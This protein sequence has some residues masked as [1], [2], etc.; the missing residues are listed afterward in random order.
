MADRQTVEA[1][2]K[3]RQ[4]T[5]REDFPDLRDRYYEP[6]LIQLESAQ[7][8]PAG[9]IVLDQQTEGACT[10]F[11]VAA[12]LNLLRQRQGS[13]SPGDGA[14]PRMLYEM[15]KLHDEWEG[16]GYEGSSVR[17]A[18]KGFFHNGACR[19]QDAPYLPGDVGWTLNVEQAKRAR[20]LSLG[21]YYRLRHVLVDYHAALQQACAI[22]V[23]VK[24]HAGWT[25]P[26]AG[27]IEYSTRGVGGH[28]FAIVGYDADGFLV[29]NSWGPNWG[30]FGGIS[31]VAHW[32]YHDWAETVIDAW[33][34]RLAV[35]TPSAFELTHRIPKRAGVGLQEAQKHTPRR[36]DVVGHVIHVDD[37]KLVEA[38]TYGTPMASLEETARMLREGASLEDRKYDHLLFYAHGGITDAVAAA[39][40][41]SA[42]REGFKR[43][44][45]YPMH[46]IWE[47]GLFEE[48]GDIV[49]GKLSDR[50][51]RVAGFA[52]ATDFLIE[53]LTAGIGRALWREMKADARRSFEPATQS[54]AAVKEIL[55]ANE[56]LDRPLKIHLVG[57]SAG[58]NSVSELLGA[59]SRLAP[60]GSAVSNCFVLGAACTIGQYERH[61]LPA[62]DE[63]T[64]EQLTI[65]N[66]SEEREL[67]DSVGPYSKSLLYLVSAAF[68]DEKEAPILGLEAHTRGLP[69]HKKQTLV[70]TK[71]NDRKRTDATSHGGYGADLTTFNDILKVICG[72]KYRAALAFRKEEL[73]NA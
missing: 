26:K 8:A 49:T 36:Q 5:V 41:T 20:N 66:L 1:G 33:V 68:E 59:W 61:L 27:K 72:A 7:P 24:I 71:G 64:L 6:A 42:M 11:A 3:E 55:R 39:R 65:Y 70:Y 43:N 21:S 25:N 60:K 62:L 16:S 44:R 63:G 18:I 34:M 10:G 48:L 32:S 12:A 13:L 2:G 46:F 19:E 56:G 22:V 17:A 4:L 53:K 38:G 40:K 30:G 28:A 50:G 31:G 37:G 15:A 14:S 29:L 35:P 47:T 52:E 69:A 73:A 54:A 45:I 23:S 51:G 67:E 58:S 9:L 57:H